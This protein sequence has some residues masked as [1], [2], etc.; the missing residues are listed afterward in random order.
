MSVLNSADSM[1]STAYT[2]AQTA[3]FVLQPSIMIAF[4]FKLSTGK[5]AN[6]DK[7]GQKW[8]DSAGQVEQAIGE[9]RE[10]IAGVTAYDW[11]ADDRT[12][13]EQKVNEICSQMET[14]HTFLTA[15][16]VALTVFGYALF[17]Y[18]VFAV[19]MG[20]ALDIMAVAAA[21]ALAGVITAELY[22]EFE[23]AAATCLTITS[24]ATAILAGVANMVGMV[25]QGGAL[26]D[27]AVETHQGNKQAFGDLKQAEEVGAAAALA[28][29]AQNGA[30]AALAY[31]NRTNGL[32][33]PGG[34]GGKIPISGVDLDADRD[35]DRTWN[36]GGGATYSKDGKDYTGAVHVKV[37]DRGF[38]GVEGEGSVKN[39]KTGDS[40]GGKA[41][42][43]EDKQG[44]DHIT[45]GV[46]HGHEPTGSTGHKESASADWNWQKQR[47]DSADV[48]GGTV[49]NGADR[50]K[51]GE[52]FTRDEHGNIVWKKP[53]V[54]TPIGDWRDGK[55]FV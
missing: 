38:Q 48:S 2:E 12:A 52:G 47:L 46:N 25:M 22:A 37:G 33:I 19:A 13:H 16:G 31:A 50:V 32:N 7:A 28:N 15:V 14:V 42:W 55:Y 9:L 18:A 3:G 35:K 36:V 8:R 54:D 53:E 20:T 34:R 44:N 11:T 29:L 10:A 43:Y 6:I 51:G 40:W 17:A 4:Q 1:M 23:A 41:G 27:A 45:A 30:N 5:A 49:D 26:L 39:T 24:V 21:A